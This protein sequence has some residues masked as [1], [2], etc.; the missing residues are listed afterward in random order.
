MKINYAKQH[1]S[2]EDIQA[3]VEVLKSD[4]ITQGLTSQ[5]FEQ[6]VCSVVGSQH[7]ISTNSGTSALHLACL[8]L[9]LSKDDIL[10][11][12]PIS[13]VASANCALYCQA[14]VDFVDIDPLTI[15]LSIP[16]LE[17]KLK[18]A[19]Q[20]QSLPKVLVVVHMSGLS[21]DMQAIYELS[22]E[23]GFAIIEDASHALGGDYQQSAIGNC[24]YSDMTVFSFHPIKSITTGEGGMVV[25]NNPQLAQELTLLRSHGI[26]RDSDLMTHAPDGDWC[27]QQLKL[28]Y[29]YRM[30]DINA[31][32][33]LSQLKRLNTF[34]DKRRQIAADYNTGLADCPILTPHPD[35]VKA[36]ACHLYI[37]ILNE[38]HHA[39]RDDLFRYLQDL[40]IMVNIHYIPIHTQPFYRDMGFKIG[41]F[42]RAEAYYQRCISLPIHYALTDENLTFIINS[43]KIFFKT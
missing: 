33:G 27:Y 16:Q 36:S 32:L 26:T 30:S 2:E 8:A 35:A 19:K 23:Y 9:K 22:Q 15:N 13:F 31:A 4:Y 42:P 21:N 38:S 10:W 1:I 17:I 3:V 7:A 14:S 20:H 43:I 41:D 25:C 40:E 11:T 34:I 6:A 28:G 29:N 24:Q 39:C 5:Q 18:H 37:I 12:S